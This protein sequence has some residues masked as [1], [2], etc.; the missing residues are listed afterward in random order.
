MNILQTEALKMKHQVLVSLLIACLLLVD[1]HCSSAKPRKRPHEKSRG[2]K[3]D[4]SRLLPRPVPVD[5]SG[6]GERNVGELDGNVPGELDGNV[7]G[8]TVKVEEGNG[9][10]RNLFMFMLQLCGDECIPNIGSDACIQCFATSVVEG[11]TSFAE[12]YNILNPPLPPSNI[13][14]PSQ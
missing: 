14:D 4:R 10:T 12:Y 7:P 3:K 11:F 5:F 9:E 8:G 13:S 6:Q 1:L 2:P